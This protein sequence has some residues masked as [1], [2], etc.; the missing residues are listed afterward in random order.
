MVPSQPPSG[1]RQLHSLCD[2]TPERAY[3]PSHIASS[4]VT[5]AQ[6]R[7]VPSAGLRFAPLLSSAASSLRPKPSGA[8]SYTHLT[9]PT[10]E[11]V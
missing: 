4:L 8:V 2:S 1:V 9:L 11:R 7:A 6:L 3:Q 10:T 5:V